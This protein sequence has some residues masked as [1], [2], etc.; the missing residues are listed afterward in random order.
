MYNLYNMSFHKNNIELAG[1]VTL[2]PKGQ[3]VIPVDAREKM[4]IKPGDKLVALYLSDSKA[5]GFVSEESMRRLIDQM[6]SHVEGLRSKLF[7][8]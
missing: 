7:R 4:E 1:T 6:G 5:V 3:V 2:G 8:N